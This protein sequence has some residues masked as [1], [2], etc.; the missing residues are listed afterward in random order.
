MKKFDIV[1][2]TCVEL[3]W[4]CLVTTYHG[5][6]DNARKQFNLDRGEPEDAEICDTYV[7][8]KDIL[9]ITEE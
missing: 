2:V 7:F 5:S 8:H 4:D 9:I 3:G 1:V 6:V